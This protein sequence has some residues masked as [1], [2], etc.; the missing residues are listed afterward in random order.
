[1][2][3]MGMKLCLWPEVKAF[4]KILTGSLKVLFLRQ[5]KVKLGNKEIVD[6][7]K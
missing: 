7:P 6:N 5:E 4:R 2:D 3:F 1:M